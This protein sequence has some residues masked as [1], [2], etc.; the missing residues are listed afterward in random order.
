VSEM[1]D[2]YAAYLRAAEMSKATI[3]G[4]VRC[5]RALHENL[6]FGLAYA[7]TEELEAFIGEG[8]WKPWTRR[9]YANHIRSFYRWADGR[10]LKANPAADMVKQR[11]P[12]SIPRPVSDEECAIALEKSPEPWK[13][14]IHLAAFQGLRLSEFARVWREDVTEETTWIRVA[15]GGDSAY[16]DTHPLVWELV[17][18]RPPGPLCRLQSGKPARPGSFSDHERAF[19]DSLGLYEVTLHRFRHWYGTKLLREG[20]DLRTVQVAM[21]H[22]SVAS[23]EGYTE[24]AGEQ[25]RLAIRS[26]PAPARRP[27]KEH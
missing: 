9:T 7:S 23:T 17:R 16:I 1:I 26:L 22:Q 5:L 10:W 11:R 12:K 14:A 2:A 18:D 20:N 15:K 8:P 13:T 21:R 6:P 4:R 27:Q 3:K 25:R 24:V 19:F